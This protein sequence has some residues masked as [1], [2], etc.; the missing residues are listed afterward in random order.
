MLLPLVSLQRLALIS[1]NAVR[2]LPLCFLSFL[3]IALIRARF[4]HLT[5]LSFIVLCL[6]PIPSLRSLILPPSVYFPLFLNL[7][8]F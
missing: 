8:V 2:F 1:T 5:C 3:L 4:K 7:A 6:T